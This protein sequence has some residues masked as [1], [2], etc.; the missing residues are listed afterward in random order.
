MIINRTPARIRPSIASVSTSAGCRIETQSSCPRVPF[1]RYV[2]YGITTSIGKPK[3]CSATGRATNLNQESPRTNHVP[4]EN[5]LAITTAAAE[6]HRRQRKAETATV[7][8]VA[9][10]HAQLRP[11]PCGKTSAAHNSGCRPGLA[12]RR[13]PRAAS[14]GPWMASKVGVVGVPST[15][16]RAGSSTLQLL[17]AQAVSLRMTVAK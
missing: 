2:R 9:G 17:P 4:S 14:E 15:S 13:V 10:R 3:F 1:A 5:P 6:P 11:R 8:H 16:L 7:H 12:S